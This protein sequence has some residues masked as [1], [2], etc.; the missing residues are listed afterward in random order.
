VAC[1]LINAPHLVA[2]FT[3]LAH[4]QKMEPNPKSSPNS[5]VG[6]RILAYLGPRREV[7]RVL[8]SRFPQ[9]GQSEYRS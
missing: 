1:A 2:M 7:S 4:Q 8:A 6:E 3:D 5:G 9:L